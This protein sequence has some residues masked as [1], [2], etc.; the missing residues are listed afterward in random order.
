MHLSLILEVAIPTFILMVVGIGLT[1]H[2]FH[3]D[4]KRFEKPKKR[5]RKKS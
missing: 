3:K 1:I 2:E 4:F 5:T